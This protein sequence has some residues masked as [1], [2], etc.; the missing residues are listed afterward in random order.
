MKPSTSDY[1]HKLIRLS[2]VMEKQ[3]FFVV[4]LTRSGTV[5]L[6]HALDAHPD[7][8]CKGE[9]HFTDS[10]YPLLG[11]A[12]TAYNKRTLLDKARLQAAGIDDALSGVSM[13]YSND[14]VRF[15]M[16]CATALTLDRLS[17]DEDVSCVGEKT[18]EHALDL[19]VLTDVFPEAKIIHVIRD[20]RDEAVS[21][22]DYNMRVNPDGFTKKFPD[23]ISFVEHFSRNWNRV[24]GA[25]HFFGRRFG[26][27]YL[28][29][30]CEDLY[31]EASTDIEQMFRFLGVSDS[32]Q[33]V[34]RSVEAGK[35]IA[36]TDGGIG[37]W[38]A[39]FDEKAE[40][41]FNRQAGE[42][43]KLLDYPV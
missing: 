42:L 29:I 32:Q 36:F 26:D 21:I 43:L 18:P 20:G 2:K 14:D 37:Q 7:A 13:G 41:S 15:M 6:Q 9:G 38:R 17:G 33:V 8:S 25:A 40:I 10:L 34:S 5:W 35:R 3:L 11:Q 19:K 39:R 12:F 16:A 28:E 4:G 23:F 22:F 30:R 24:V 31:T 27:G 1:R